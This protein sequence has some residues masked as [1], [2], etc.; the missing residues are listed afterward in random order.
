VF[1]VGQ[2]VA[3]GTA[4]DS[5]NRIGD[6]TKA[7]GF[8]MNYYFHIATPSQPMGP[9]TTQTSVRYPHIPCNL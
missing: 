4:L 9:Y 1:K 6:K 3:D 8:K 7:K 5:L 2:G